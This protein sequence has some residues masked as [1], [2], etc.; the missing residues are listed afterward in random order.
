MSRREVL[1]R[2]EPP[3]TAELSGIVKALRWPRRESL[4]TLGA[5]RILSGIAQKERSSA[6]KMGHSLAREFESR[7]CGSDKPPSDI[8]ITVLG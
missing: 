6:A 4:G 5:A 8:S 7:T 2:L 3:G 1:R